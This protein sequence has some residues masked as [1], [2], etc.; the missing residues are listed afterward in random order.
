MTH[1]V[2]SYLCSIQTGLAR[3]TCSWELLWYWKQ[4]KAQLSFS[5]WLVG[6][7]L[8]CSCRWITANWPCSSLWKYHLLSWTNFFLKKTFYSICISCFS[9]IS[10]FT[11]GKDNAG[12]QKFCTSALFLSLQIIVAFSIKSSW[13]IHLQK[14]GI[15]SDRILQSI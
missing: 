2:G 14:R 10:S 7:V 3:V 11:Q 5:G 6:A 15:L 1:C 12:F 4:E 13:W 9:F 8:T